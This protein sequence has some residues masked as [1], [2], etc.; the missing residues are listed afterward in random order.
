MRISDI[1]RE[2]D[3]STQVLDYLVALDAEGVDDIPMDV[4]VDGLNANGI[5]VDREG[6]FD[7]LQNLA[8]VGNI[9]ND[10]VYFTST[11]DASHYGVKHDPEKDDKKVDKMA[12]KQVKKELSK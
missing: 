2:S 6:L 3:I 4:L 8:I 12:R 10:V 9:K 1:I 5:S 7:I 11:S